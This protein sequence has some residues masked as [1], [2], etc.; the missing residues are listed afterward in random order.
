[1]N[2]SDKLKNPLWQ[3]KR[4]EIFKR[5]KWKCKKCGDT[6]TTLCVHH[7]EYS[8]GEPWDIDNKFLVTLCEHC[9]TEIEEITIQTKC[10]FSEIKILKIISKSNYGRF[11]ISKFLDVIHV[12]YYNSKN[13][14][15][16]DF[17]SKESDFK[18][19]INKL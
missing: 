5:D 19:I 3:K 1:M 15:F 13:I 7:L 6:K 14:F 9:H 2:Y 17:I 11:M 10:C 12:S 18:E 4:L 16:D 8:N